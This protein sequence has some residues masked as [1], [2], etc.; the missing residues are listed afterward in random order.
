MVQVIFFN[1]FQFF[2]VVHIHDPSTLLSSFFVIYYYCLCA[3]IPPSI[4]INYK[5][6]LA[7]AVQSHYYFF[8][9]FCRKCNLYYTTVII[10]MTVS[11]TYTAGNS[12]RLDSNTVGIVCMFA[13]I[14]GIYD[15]TN[16]VYLSRHL[17]LEEFDDKLVRLS[18]GLSS[19]TTGELQ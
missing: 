11:N 4:N 5:P 12:Q 1:V 18:I 14:Y 3:I 9:L 15:R 8:Q 19:R 10:L 7:V 17:V 6:F 13:S 16:K 2:L